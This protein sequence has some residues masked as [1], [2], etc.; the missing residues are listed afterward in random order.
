M[1]QQRRRRKRS[2]AASPSDFCTLR[3]VTRRRGCC[4]RLT[5]GF[6]RAAA[7]E[8]SCSR[9]PIYWNIFGRKRKGGKLLLTSRPFPSQETLRSGK[10][11]SLRF[12]KFCS[13][14]FRR[15]AEEIP[16]NFGSS[17]SICGRDWKMNGQKARA[18]S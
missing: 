9:K 3:E 4:C 8:K 1:P 6:V 11:S 7:K 18:D 5:R 2:G 17:S 12:A 16:R 14:D 10:R 15:H 13:G